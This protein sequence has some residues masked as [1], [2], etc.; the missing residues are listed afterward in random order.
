MLISSSSRFK[1]VLLL[2]HHHIIN[3]MCYNL[4]L[5]VSCWTMFCFIYFVLLMMIICSSSGS[6]SNSSSSNS[7]CLF[8]YLFICHIEW[9]T[10]QDWSLLEAWDERRNGIGWRLHRIV[11]QSPTSTGRVTDPPSRA[12]WMGGLSDW[13]V[14]K[15]VNVVGGAASDSPVFR[16]GAYPAGILTSFSS[17]CSSFSPR[18]TR[19]ATLFI[20]PAFSP[21]FRRPHAR[22]VPLRPRGQLRCGGGGILRV[23]R[24][25]LGA[26]VR[27]QPAQR[28]P[29][30][31][32]VLHLP[33]MAKGEENSRGN[34]TC[35]VRSLGSMTSFLFR[36]FLSGLG[37]D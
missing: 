4:F 5:Y 36:S 3:S 30:V 27:V 24:P 29:S 11:K 33:T 10:S 21:F 1:F 23:R 25:P 13:S 28:V 26:Q 31:P 2:Y 18:Q 22:P 35:V 9:K 6:S 17:A 14:V 12:G 8:V 15:D 34:R 16:E 19:A 7:C 32:G 37:E 20:Y